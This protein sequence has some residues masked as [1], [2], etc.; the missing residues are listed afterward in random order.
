M[1]DDV[2]LGAIAQIALSVKDEGR[3]TPFNRDQLRI[4]IRF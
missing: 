1:P 3:A 2:R 4:P